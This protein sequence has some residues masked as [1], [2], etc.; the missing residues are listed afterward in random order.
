MS[1]PPM[2]KKDKIEVLIDNRKKYF[3]N[4]NENNETD[5][6]EAYSYITVESFKSWLMKSY[7]DMDYL[8]NIVKKDLSSLSEKK[9]K[10]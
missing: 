2:I 7:L 6:L 1:P 9:V 3:K 8:K 10:I 4:K 5:E